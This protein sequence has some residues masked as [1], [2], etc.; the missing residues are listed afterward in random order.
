[1]Y[2]SCE[3]VRLRLLSFFSPHSIRAESSHYLRHSRQEAYPVPVPIPVSDADAD[4]DRCRY[5]RTGLN[6]IIQDLEDTVMKAKKRI[7]E[8]FPS[9]SNSNSNSTSILTL[10]DSVSV[11]MEVGV[12]EGIITPPSSP[13]ERSLSG[14]PV[15]GD[16][17]KE[18]S[19][20]ISTLPHPSTSV[21]DCPPWSG[22]EAH[23]E[24]ELELMLPPTPPSSI[25][26]VSESESD[27]ES[28]PASKPDSYFYPH[29]NGHSKTSVEDEASISSSVS[30]IMEEERVGPRVTV[31]AEPHDFFTPQSSTRRG[32][33]Y[34]F[35]LKWVL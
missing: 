16:D 25:L 1:M 11:E 13:S 8:A 27:I 21:P 5:E 20:S 22:E 7:G 24:L 3:A 26:S 23:R 2:R 15:P 14:S 9:T 33:E 30:S 29:T 34:C 17:A 6:F 4:F 31:T 10:N 32:D 12:E 19:I 35:V 18:S 28:T